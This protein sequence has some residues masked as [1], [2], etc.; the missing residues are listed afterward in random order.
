MPPP[1]LPSST[2][3][4]FAESSALEHMFFLHV[5]SSYIL[6]SQAIVGLTHKREKCFVD[7]G[8]MFYKPGDRSAAYYGPTMLWVF[9]VE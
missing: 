4:Y 1:T 3:S 7:N 9:V 5:G 2:G 6:F 8:K